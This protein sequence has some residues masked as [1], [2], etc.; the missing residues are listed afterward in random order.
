[1]T[2]F[3]PVLA[4]A[5]ATGLAAAADTQMQWRERFQSVTPTNF[6]QGG[7]VSHQFH[8]HA[9]SYLTTATVTAP[10]RA[11]A[12]T[13]NPSQLLADLNVRHRN[14]EDPFS[15]YVA[16]EPWISS[17]IVLHAGEVVFEAY[18]RMRADQRHFAWS[19]SKVVTA[20]VIA[21]LVNDGLVEMDQTVSHYL[22]ELAGSEWSDVTVTDVAN[23][24]SGIDC[25]DSD[26]YQNPATCIYRM[27]E[28]L[29]ITADR[30]YEAGLI[31]HLAGMG[32]R[33]PPG[34]VFEYVSANTN[35]LGL[36]AEAA[37][38]QPFVA[39]LSEQ[40]WRPVGAESDALLAINEEGFSY[41]SGGVTARLRD[42]ARFGEIFVDPARSGVISDALVG[43]MQR[44]GVPFNEDRQQRL[45][46]EF[47]DDAP[48]RAAWQWDLIW[49]DGGMY[50]GG[51][52]GQGL[53]VDPERELVIAWFGTGEDF[54]ALE[55]EMPA[56]SRQIAR[57]GLFDK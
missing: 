41:F 25:L 45:E 57:A 43:A 27:E 15:R 44:G 34:E 51:Y 33:G 40:I 46:T 55:N 3:L 17:V 28:T 23:M 13:V 21:A 31:E 49:E 37:T 8:L 56:V 35:V 6:D 39:V 32:R 54:S 18:P 24:S 19:V 48:R 11:R 50:K 5:V 53:Y 47:G 16:A 1:M 2:K 14:G 20:A 4:L 36:I 9:E 42:I 12:L 7:A 38:G 29:G 52:L 10:A 22:P 26:G 30:G